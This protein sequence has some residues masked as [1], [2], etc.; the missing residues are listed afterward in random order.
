[1]IIYNKTGLANLRLQKEAQEYLRK[2]CITDAEF[3][4]ISE[5]YPADFYTPNLFVRVGL[6]ILTFI[7]SLFAFGLLTLMSSGSRIIDSPGWPLFRGIVSYIALEVIV[8][9]KNHHHSGVDDALLIISACAIGTG[10]IWM[11]A[12]PATGTDYLL[13]SAIIF[14]LSLLLAIRYAHLLMSAVCCVSFFAFVFSGGRKL[15]L[16]AYPVPLLS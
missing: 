3:K 14:L 2:G 7:I 11:L 6:F 16:M 8:A 4:T 10:F 13:L 12:N 15:F 9:V 5:K 1:M